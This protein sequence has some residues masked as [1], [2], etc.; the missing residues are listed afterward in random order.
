MATNIESSVTSAQTP[1]RESRASSV[2]A[3][4]GVPRVPSPLNDVNKTYLPGSP[5]RAELKARLAQMAAER[6]EIPLVIGG[7]RIKTAR[8]EQAVM[9]HDHTH[10]LADWHVAEREHVQ[11][12]VAAAAVAHREWASW[13]WQ[14]RA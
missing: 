7:K 10:V 13:S 8:V 14:D 9:P 1:A 5:E 4:A 11:Q 12:A 2:A 6:I 3:F